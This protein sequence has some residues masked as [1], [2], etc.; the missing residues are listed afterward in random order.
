MIH[1][2]GCTF[3]EHNLRLI[4]LAA[5]VCVAACAAAIVMMNRAQTQE[6]IARAIWI[7]CAGAVGG[8]GIWATHFIAMLA[9]NKNFPIAFDPAVTFLSIAIASVMCAVGIA[10]ALGRAGALVGGTVMGLAIAVMHYVGMSGVRAPADQLW[11]ANY[12]VASVLTGTALMALG[13]IVAVRRDRASL[14]AG[15]FIFTL[16]ICAMHFTGMAALTLRPNP[17]I[18]IPDVVLAPATLAVSIAAAA[19]LVISISLIAVLFDRQRTSL[20]TLR[21]TAAQL[22]QL[23][24]NLQTA[25]E[26][27]NSANRAKASFFAAMSH[28]L[29][30]PLNAIIGFSELLKEEIFSPLGDPRNAQYVRDIHNSGLRLLAIINDVLDMSRMDAGK[31]PLQETEIVLDDMVARAL[32]TVE[33]QAKK[34]GVRLVKNIPLGLPKIRGDVQRLEQVLLNLLTNAIKFTHPSGRVE[35]R[36]RLNAA[37][38]Y[39]DVADTGIGIAE[40][41]ID[42]VLTPFVQVDNTLA[43][44]YE[45]TGLGLPIAKKLIEL[46][47]GTLTLQSTLLVGTTATIT[48]P[49]SR[50]VSP[51]RAIADSS[52][53]EMPKLHAAVV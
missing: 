28:E 2:L 42:K 52:K 7:G 30:T 27:A 53:T 36:V 46:H 29:R 41:N 48:L 33:I 39:I 37:G 1:V 15:T 24:G 26:E 32:H 16:A 34:A 12:I 38:L 4:A 10:L 44:K 8:F 21:A 11:D 47:G 45:G 43:R 3:D 18:A 19:F 22:E 20:K 13:M 5:I 51:E 23:S 17:T 50:L 49:V 40:E 35:A 9:Y 25:L 6:G 14:P 31:M